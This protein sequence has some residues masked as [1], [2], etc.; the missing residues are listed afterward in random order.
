MTGNEIGVEGAKAMSKILKVN[1]TLTSLN[2][3]GEER[4]K[5]GWKRIER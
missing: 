4:R 2:L 3:G 5:E 1:A